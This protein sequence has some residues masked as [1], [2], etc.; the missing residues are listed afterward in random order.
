MKT[1]LISKRDVDTAL[2]A[3]PLTGKNLLEPFARFAA[4]KELP[5]SILEDTAVSNNAE[6]HTREG[7]LWFCL[8]GEAVFVCGGTLSEPRCRL[9]PDGSENK[10]ELY[11]K[12]IKDGKEFVVKAG[13][14]LWIPAGEPH[15]HSARGTA[16]LIIVKIPLH[17]LS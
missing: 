7:D 12:E 2:S 10:N 3:L 16:R 11:S 4:E 8:Q 13:D 5:F 15:Q 17:R 1:V 6:V 14:W 9:Y